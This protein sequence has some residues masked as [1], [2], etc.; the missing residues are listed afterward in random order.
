[1]R[2]LTADPALVSGKGLVSANAGT[3][4]SRSNRMHDG[5]EAADI[6]IRLPGRKKFVQARVVVGDGRGYVVGV[7][8]QNN[9]DGMIWLD[10][11]FD[12]FQIVE[13]KKDGEK[14]EEKKD[15]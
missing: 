9:P 5:H 11:F 7:S 12:G 15:N 10:E 14:K 4:L 3:E 6:L 1:M 8:V 2:L 13:A